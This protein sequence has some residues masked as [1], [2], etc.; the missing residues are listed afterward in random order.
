MFWVGSRTSDSDHLVPRTTLRAILAMSIKGYAHKP[1][2][3]MDSRKAEMDPHALNTLL[4]PRSLHNDSGMTPSK[5]D[6]GS[7]AAVVLDAM[8]LAS[9][10][11]QSPSNT[12]SWPTHGM[13]LRWFAREASSRRVHESRLATSSSLQQTT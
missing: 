3:V 2:L 4:S 9:G 10:G 11:W 12:Q 5:K 7:T 8:A 6:K 13:M 1:A